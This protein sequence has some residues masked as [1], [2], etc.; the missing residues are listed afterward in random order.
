MSLLLN[1]VYRFDEFELVLSGRVLSRDGTQLPLSPKAFEVLT[2]LVI[3][4]GRVVTK[5]E[6]LK[7]VWPQSFVEEGNLSQQ[8]SALRK[9]LADKSTYIVTIP[10]RGYQFTA[11]VTSEAQQVEPAHTPAKEAH[12]Q[13]K[14]EDTRLTIEKPDIH[15]LGSLGQ[16]LPPPRRA[17]HVW[18]TTSIAIAVLAIAPLSIIAYW[19]MVRYDKSVIPRV[20]AYFQITHDGREKSL[21]GTDGS[22]LYFTQKSPQMGA[23]VAVAGGVIAPVPIPV[24]KSWLGSVSPD[25]STILILT[26]AGGM[27]SSESMSSLGLLGGPLRHLANAIASTWSPDGETVAYSTQEGDL[28]LIRSDGTQARKLASVGGYLSSLSWAPDGSVLRFSKNGQLWEITLEGKHL[29]QLLSHWQN[30][31]SI[32]EGQFAPDGKFYFIN[33]GQLWTFNNNLDASVAQPIA[34]TA[35]PIRWRDLIPGK[36]PNTLFAVGRTLRGELVRSNRESGQ[37][38]PF[39]AGIS[40][41]FLSFS[42]DGNSVAYVTFPDGILWRAHRDGSDALQLTSPPVYPKLIRWSPDGTQIV[43]VDRTP[44][45][46]SGIYVVPSGGGALPRRLLPDDVETETDPTWSPEGQRIAFSTSPEEYL[47]PRPVV[48]ILDL[49]RHQVT[50]LPGS[51]GLYSPR[52]SPDG[53]N[54]LAVTL[55]SLVTKVF[56]FS[57]QQWSALKSGPIAFPEWSHDSRFIYYI[58]WSDDPAVLRTNVADGKTERVANLN[59]EQYTGFYSVWMS[60]DPTDSPLMLCDRGSH[61]IYALRLQ[62]R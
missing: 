51:E 49:V 50:T 45:G 37:F 29:H 47:N 36:D 46:L 48:R 21:A 6:I 30:S 28:Y 4:S 60:L 31:S 44:Q 3:N 11:R 14:Q 10:G 26:E 9:T 32:S 20:S 52:W 16:T 57:T 7:A 19:A 12:P 35:G 2:H 59:G 24:P 33:A 22:R 23:Q 62:G 18:I 54:L 39:L 55:D 25:G 5:D 41:E 43:F 8:V 61:D 53:H 42:N 34:L 27:T 17:I 40:A 13:D 38:L 56:N 15:P 58:S 1:D